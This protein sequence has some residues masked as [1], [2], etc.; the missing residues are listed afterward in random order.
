MP[1][2]TVAYA[3]DGWTRLD[4][5]MSWIHRG[6]TFGVLALAVAGF[7]MSYGALYG[8][9]LEEGVPPRLAWLW[10][11][12]VDGFIVVASLA[13]L[14]AVLERRSTAYPW[15]LVLGFSAVSVS[16]NVVHAAPNPVARLVAAVPPL[17]L[18]LSFELLMRQ[19][20][21]ALAA[22]LV[23]ATP[24]ASVSANGHCPAIE[25]PELAE[26][27]VPDRA[28]RVVE[29]H[30]L[31]GR[32]VTGV[33]LARELGISDGYGRRLLRQLSADASG[34]SSDAP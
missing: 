12:V 16:F 31:A 10:P 25:A 22:K 9:A 24:P 7:A 34:V 13:V 27:S 17:A 18:V 2:L 21:A 33:V 8:L 6:T 30:R 4:R 3:A 14:H 1:L 5:S 29:E 15:A 20:R 19:V 26:A 23:H 11:L 28:R 32:Q